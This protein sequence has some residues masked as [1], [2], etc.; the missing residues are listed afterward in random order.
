MHDIH[1]KDECFRVVLSTRVH[2]TTDIGT[3]RYE[4]RCLLT[5]KEIG[6]FLKSI[7]HKN[8]SSIGLYVRRLATLNINYIIGVTQLLKLFASD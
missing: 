7:S 6:V 4:G 5:C 2:C 1:N 3:D 8:I